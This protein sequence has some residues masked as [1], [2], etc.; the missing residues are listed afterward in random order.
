[1]LAVLEHMVNA[2]GWSFN[3]QV[4]DFHPSNCGKMK[5]TKYFGWV[6]GYA[7]LK[8]CIFGIL[9]SHG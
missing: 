4:I 7:A 9:R 2:G 3:F 1:M 5:A 6:N 8:L